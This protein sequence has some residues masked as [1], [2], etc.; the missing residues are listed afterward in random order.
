MGGT[1]GGLTKRHVMQTERLKESMLA[2]AEELRRLHARIHET[3]KLR[4]R[5][6]ECHR[7]WQVA[8]EIF[9]A[10]YDQLAFP[11]GYGG[12]LERIA[13]SEPDAVE[14]ALCFLEL[15][16]YFFRSGYMYKDILR[17]TKRAVLTK[18]QAARLAHI[19]AA[20]QQ[21]RA[22]RRREPET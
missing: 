16:P 3:V 12:A 6:A 14:A 1:V 8:C 18:T 20:Y 5:G 11:G 21:Y 19:V 10:R 7:E 13:A 15:R 9:H 22:Q 2:N 4:N 17:K